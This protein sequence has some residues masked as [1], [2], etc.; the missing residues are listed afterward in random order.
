MFECGTAL[1]ETTV[2][3]E[4][5]RLATPKMMKIWSHSAMAKRGRNK[6]LEGI[7]KI[8]RDILDQITQGKFTMDDKVMPK[9]ETNNP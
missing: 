6:R 4:R 3:M 9:L 7:A 5:I 1:R 8:E 2:V